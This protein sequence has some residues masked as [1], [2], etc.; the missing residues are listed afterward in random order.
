M[1]NDASICI[2][3][4]FGHRESNARS[5]RV[6][7]AAQDSFDNRFF[8]GMAS[9]SGFAQW[10]QNGFSERIAQSEDFRGVSAQRGRGGFFGRIVATELPINASMVCH[11]SYVQR[12]KLLLLFL[13]IDYCFWVIT[14][15]LRVRL[16]IVQVSIFFLINIEIRNEIIMYLES[17]HM[18]ER[19][20]S[21]YHGE[22]KLKRKF[23]KAKVSVHLHINLYQKKKKYP[24]ITK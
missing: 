10:R 4:P 11:I 21:S 6:S 8:G 23:L 2:I 18:L 19:G 12:L 15:I 13:Q 14:R 3:L 17:P 16:Y 7:R 24:F 20:V 5:V 22:Y 1:I 9:L